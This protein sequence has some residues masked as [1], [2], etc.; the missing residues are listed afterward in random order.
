MQISDWESNEAVASELG[1]RVKAVR[2]AQPLTQAELAERAG[3]SV[4][5]VSNLERGRDVTT[6]SLIRILRALGLLSHMECLVPDEG[7]RPRD[8]AA[9]GA[10][11]KRA[12]SPARRKPTRADNWK[13]GDER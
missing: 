11:R 7:P 5:T 8:I 3:V 13:W 2:I 10:P 9:L 4:G 1:R 12:T 6:G